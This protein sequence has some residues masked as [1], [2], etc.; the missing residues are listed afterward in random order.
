MM[1]SIEKIIEV[2]REGLP[3]YVYNN[4][5]LEI[6]INLGKENRKEYNLIDKRRY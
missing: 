4:P 5:W 2:E 1:K 6:L 3:S